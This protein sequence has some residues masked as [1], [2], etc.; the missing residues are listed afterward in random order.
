MIP[1]YYLWAKANNIAS[2]QFESDVLAFIFV[3]ISFVDMH[4][5]VAVLQFIGEGDGGGVYLKLDV[6]VQWGE[7]ILDA[8]RQGTG[9]LENQAIYMDAICVH[10]ENKRNF[11]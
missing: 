5:A 10:C 8:D 7:K 2:I 9:G 11:T 4:D 6:Q 3:L 1:L